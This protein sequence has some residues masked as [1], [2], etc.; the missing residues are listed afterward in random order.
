MIYILESEVSKIVDQ[1]KVELPNECCGFLS[2]IK[3]RE[4][5][6]ITEAAALRNTDESPEHF[7]MDPK[8]QFEVIRR[9]RGEKVSLLGNYHSHPASPARPS[10]EDKRLAYDENMIYGIISFLEAPKLKLFKITKDLVEELDFK[11]I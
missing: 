1:G 10:E 11:I 6:F 5:I 7:S 8:E 4:N 2:G 3:V 9:F